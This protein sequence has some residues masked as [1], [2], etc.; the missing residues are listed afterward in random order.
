[1]SLVLCLGPSWAQQS[2]EPVTHHC[3]SGHIWAQQENKH[4]WCDVM[5][6]GSY[7]GSHWAQHEKNTCNAPCVGDRILAN[8]GPK[9]T[10][11]LQRRMFTGWYLGP[12]WTPKAISYV[13]AHACWVAFAPMLGP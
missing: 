11:N 9:R 5:C 6:L 3:L 4:V 13:T 1:M 7:W 12:L 8:V 10:V 2:I